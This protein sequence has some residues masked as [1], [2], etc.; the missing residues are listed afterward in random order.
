MKP[1]LKSFQR[2]FKRGIVYTFFQN[3]KLIKRKTVIFK[4]RVKF[5]FN[6]GFGQIDMHGDILLPGSFDKSIKDVNIIT[7]Q[8]GENTYKGL[9]RE[10]PMQYLYDLSEGTVKCLVFGTPKNLL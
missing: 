2:P 8:R 9:T 1:H 10:Y 3:G 5:T 7:W 6:V 4:K